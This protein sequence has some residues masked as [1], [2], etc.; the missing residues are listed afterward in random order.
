MTDTFIGHCELVYKALAERSTIRTNPVTDEPELAFVGA[1]VPV[2]KSLNLSQS[3]YSPIFKTLEDVGAILKVQT[4]GRGV[5]TVMLLRGLPDEWPEGLGWKGSRSNPLTEDSRYGRLL[6]LVQEIEKGTI[7]GIDV[8][9]ALTELESRVV[10]LE[11]KVQKM[12]AHSN[13]NKQ[14]QVK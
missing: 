13:G 12:E 5:D 3:Y 4:G 8:I 14:K 6:E 10:A 11:S 1:I 9:L 2:Y 7:K